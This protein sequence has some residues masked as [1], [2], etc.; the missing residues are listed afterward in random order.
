MSKT[1]ASF[2]EDVPDV[3]ISAFVPKPQPDQKAPTR[4]EV[5]EVAEAANFPSR[6]APASVPQKTPKKPA[7]R[8]YRTGR[9]VQFNAKISKETNEAIYNTTD[10]NGW[11]LGYT[12]ERAMAALR[13]ELEGSR[14]TTRQPDP[15][16]S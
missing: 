11:V 4:E 7:T 5:R 10:S 8:V 12:L 15:V 13:K 14:P 9:N 6:Q 16:D 1:R 2:F 3:D